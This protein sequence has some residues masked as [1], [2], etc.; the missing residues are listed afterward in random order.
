MALSSCITLEYV[1]RSVRNQLR[2][3][4]RTF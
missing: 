1:L 4:T 3:Y 2:G